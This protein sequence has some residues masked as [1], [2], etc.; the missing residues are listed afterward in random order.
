[1]AAHIGSGIAKAVMNCDLSSLDDRCGV[2]ENRIDLDF[3]SRETASADMLID[4]WNSLAQS[5]ADKAFIYEIW[6]DWARNRMA[7]DIDP[8]E[9]RCTALCWGG[10]ILIG[11]PGEVFAQSALRLRDSI[12]RDGIAAEYPVFIIAYADDNPGY[13]PPR[14][15]YRSGGYEIDEAH[16]FYGLGATFAP[17]S[18]E[19]LEQTGCL[20]A[21]N[22]A[23]AAAQNERAINNSTI[24]RGNNG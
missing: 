1:M 2:A 20:V 5:D 16:R 17:G 13:I 14:A 24:E 11:L 3:L 4:Q 15:E 22:A 10:S 19:R 8:L 7:K 6:I 12:A 9:V 18:A 23:V 21:K